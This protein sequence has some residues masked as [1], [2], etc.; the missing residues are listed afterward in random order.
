MDKT[1]VLETLDTLPQEFS[2]E[3]LIE[4]LLFIEKIE[5]AQTEV[6][7]G[8]KISLEEAKKRFGK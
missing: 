1:K 8:K 4:R 7:L 5:Q 3:E 6:A 2:T